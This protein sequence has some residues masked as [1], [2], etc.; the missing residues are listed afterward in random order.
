MSTAL[1]AVH[2]LQV[3][4]PILESTTDQY[5]QIKVSSCFAAISNC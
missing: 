1:H 2:S 3:P 5:F 4:Y